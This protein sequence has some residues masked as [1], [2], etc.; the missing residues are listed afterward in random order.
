MVVLAVPILLTGFFMDKLRE[1]AYAV[2]A[3]VAIVAVIFKVLESKVKN[4]FQNNPL[5]QREESDDSKPPVAGP[6]DDE[7]RRREM[8]QL[9]ERCGF[10]SLEELQPHF[11]ES[12]TFDLLP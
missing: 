9:L 1:S 12:S 4:K 5:S 3:L 10:P 8:D 2:V 6:L 11:P 7:E